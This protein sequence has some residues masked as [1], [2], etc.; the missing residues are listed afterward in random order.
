MASPFRREDGLSSDPA[1]CNAT[2][3]CWHASSAFVG[4]NASA[5]SL[6]HRLGFSPVRALVVMP[7]YNESENLAKMIP[8]LRDA[9][10]DAD[11][12]I[13]DDSSPDGTADI[14]RNFMKDDEAVHLLSR[15]AKSGLGGAYREGFKWGIERGFDA[16]IEMDADFSHDPKQLPSLLAAAAEGAGLVI[17]SRYVEGGTIPKWSRRRIMLSKGGNLYSS[18]LLGLKVKDATAGF[19][20]YSPEALGLIHYEEVTLDGYGFQVEMTY[21]ARRAGVKI[22]EVPISFVDR[23]V[24][25]SKMSGSI[26][27]EALVMVTRRGFSRLFGR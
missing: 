14:V 24:G 21:R 2:L 11:L 23:E 18:A 22:V 12:L 1:P 3:L 20:V 9:V 26:V 17:G 13:V 7:T 27:V 4:S 15:P 8:A 5:A 25:E 16:L 10:P 19:R 6:V